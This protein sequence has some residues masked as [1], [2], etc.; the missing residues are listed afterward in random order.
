M[1]GTTCD[2]TDESG[3]IWYK[4]EEIVKYSVKDKLWART[5]WWQ[6]IENELTGCW[7]TLRQTLE[8]DL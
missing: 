1:A 5:R 6:M 8:K 7:D 2:D 4:T 3:S